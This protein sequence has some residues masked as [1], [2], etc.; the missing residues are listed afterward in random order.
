MKT[1]SIFPI[2]AFLRLCGIVLFLSTAITATVTEAEAARPVSSTGYGDDASNMVSSNLPMM[3]GNGVRSR[4]VDK[5][6]I[7]GSN[8]SRNRFFIPGCPHEIE[9]F[10]T[11]QLRLFWEEGWNLG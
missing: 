6:C 9:L 3:L 5:K 2:S 4:R 10:N 11:A 7:Y 1:I 8:F